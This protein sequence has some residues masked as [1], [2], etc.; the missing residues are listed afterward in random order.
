MLECTVGCDAPAGQGVRSNGTKK[1]KLL[2]PWR[3][4]LGCVLNSMH[5][6]ASAALFQGARGRRA[7]AGGGCMGWIPDI[8]QKKTRKKMY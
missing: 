6:I 8:M 4:S 5:S 3:F 2:R 1:K 7:L